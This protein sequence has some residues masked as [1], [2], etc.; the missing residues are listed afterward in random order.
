MPLFSDSVTTIKSVD[1][2][3][4]IEATAQLYFEREAAALQ[5][6]QIF[7]DNIALYNT[8]VALRS[9]LK[10]KNAFLLKRMYE[11]YKRKKVPHIYEQNTNKQ[12]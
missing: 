4:S 1:E 9:Q 5:Q 12:P 2:G 11:H 10:I 3:E 8:H 6:Q 7:Q